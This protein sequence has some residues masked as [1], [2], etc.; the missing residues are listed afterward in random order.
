MFS[1]NIKYAEEKESRKKSI[2]PT[3]RKLCSGQEI[4]R[5]K[6]VYRDVESCIKLNKNVTDFLYGVEAYG[7][8]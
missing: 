2:E 1:V 4:R 8:V 7:K 3:M 6:H 5:H